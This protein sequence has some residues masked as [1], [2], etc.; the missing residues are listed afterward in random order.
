M[1]RINTCF[2]FVLFL[3]FSFISMADS[4]DDEIEANKDK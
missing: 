1:I 3:T 4:L 2:V